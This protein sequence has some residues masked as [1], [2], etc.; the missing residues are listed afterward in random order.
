MR[1]LAA[2]RTFWE[3]ATA[4]SC[5]IPPPGGQTAA[6]RLSGITHDIYRLY[7]QDIGRRALEHKLLER[8]IQHKRLFFSQAWAHYETAKPGTFH[9]LPAGDVVTA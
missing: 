2:E 8:V 5:R 9:L 3:K 1:T 4:A 6:Q 7:G